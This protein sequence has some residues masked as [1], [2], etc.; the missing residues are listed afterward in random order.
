MLFNVEIK[1]Q[2]VSVQLNSVSR[3]SLPIVCRNDA[4]WSTAI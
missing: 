1:Q 4:V 3:V 2:N